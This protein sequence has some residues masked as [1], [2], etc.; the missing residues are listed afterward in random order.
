MRLGPH[1]L[2]LYHITA[3]HS[4]SP[5]SILLWFSESCHRAA[6]I[7]LWFYKVGF[8]SSILLYRTCHVLCVS[9]NLSSSFNNLYI[10]NL[11]VP[12]IIVDSDK[13]WEISHHLYPDIKWENLFSRWTK[14]ALKNSTHINYPRSGDGI[15]KHARVGIPK[16]A[17]SGSFTALFHLPGAC[18]L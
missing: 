14:Y 15:Q 12:S 3:T 5:V 10:K 8:L 16:R 17:H 2:P 13:V 9:Q 18:T 7:P 6:S 4:N 11:I 1:P